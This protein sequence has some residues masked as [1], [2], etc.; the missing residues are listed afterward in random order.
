MKYWLLSSTVE[1]A[2]FAI[3]REYYT[4]FSTA[5]TAVIFH[6]HLSGSDIWNREVFYLPDVLPC[7][8]HGSSDSIEELEYLAVMEALN[9]F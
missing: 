9:V 8:I 3:F 6:K 1:K 4:G 2:K 5:S 7:N